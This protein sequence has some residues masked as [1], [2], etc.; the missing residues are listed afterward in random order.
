MKISAFDSVVVVRNLPEHGLLRGDVGDV[1]HVHDPGD[2]EVE[3]V[4]P[5][6]RPTAVVTL[7]QGDVRVVV[8]GRG[9]AFDG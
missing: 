4:S 6:G 8:K 5:V 2:F 9:S 7:H 1:V 3:F